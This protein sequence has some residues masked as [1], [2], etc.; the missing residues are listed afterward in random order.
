MKIELKVSIDRVESLLEFLSDIYNE[1][2]E[3]YQDVEAEP[4]DSYAEEKRKAKRQ[5]LRKLNNIRNECSTQYYYWNSM[6]RY[7]KRIETIRRR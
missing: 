4:R 1:T 7:M 5:E 2:T 6:L 3:R